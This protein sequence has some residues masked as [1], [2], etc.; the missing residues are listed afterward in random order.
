MARNW[1]S[2][3][4][5]LWRSFRGTPWLCDGLVLGATVAAISSTSAL[6][7]SSAL[8]RFPMRAGPTSGAFSLSPATALQQAVIGTACHE[9]NALRLHTYPRSPAGHVSTLLGFST[10]T[11]VTETFMSFLISFIIVTFSVFLVREMR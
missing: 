2:A 9:C 10:D 7:F 3:C 6:A 8:M 5:S 4:A 11:I 1:W